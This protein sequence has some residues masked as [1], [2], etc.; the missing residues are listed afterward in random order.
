MASFRTDLRAAEVVTALQ[1]LQIP[2]LV[3]ADTSS[4]WQRVVAGPFQTREAAV[5]AQ[6][7]LTRSGY[8]DTRISQIP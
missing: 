2:A 6:D 1:G 3:R 8:A 4:G 5:A 7:T